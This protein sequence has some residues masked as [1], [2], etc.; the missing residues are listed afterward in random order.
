[1]AKAMSFTLL[2]GKL[3]GYQSKYVSHV[4]SARVCDV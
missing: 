2:S 3:H 4:S 1:M